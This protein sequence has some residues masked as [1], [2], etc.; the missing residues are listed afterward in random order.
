MDLFPKHNKMSSLSASRR[1]GT[2][3]SPSPQN[4]A[5]SVCFTSGM[6]YTP[7]QLPSCL[8]LH[9]CS[10]GL[11]GVQCWAPAVGSRAQN[12]GSGCRQHN[13]AAWSII[14]ASGAFGLLHQQPQGHVSQGQ[15]HCSLGTRA[16]CPGRQKC[17][18]EMRHFLH[19]AAADGTGGW[20]WLKPKHGPEWDQNRA[21]LQGK[22]QQPHISS[23]RLQRWGE[24]AAQ[25]KSTHTGVIP[26]YPKD[27]QHLGLLASPRPMTS[28]AMQ[29]DGGFPSCSCSRL[30][31][32]SLSL[33][34][35]LWSTETQQ[36][37]LKHCWLP[38]GGTGTSSSQHHLQLHF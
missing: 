32:G 8:P 11:M 29:E 28:S 34:R 13:T 12:R 1:L 38:A 14:R 4:R 7:T 31:Q 25:H 22:S 16:S 20:V 5:D 36:Q 6:E 35:G 18:G 15:P 21:Q 30:G 27:S 10:E 37:L 19:S 2:C 9:D 33:Q 23:C 26:V 24:I 17:S 3:C